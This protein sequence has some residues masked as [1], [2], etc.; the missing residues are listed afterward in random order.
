MSSYPNHVLVLLEW[1]DGALTPGGVS[2]DEPSTLKELVEEIDRSMNASHFGGQ[3]RLTLPST[4]LVS[5]LL[6]ARVA[7]DNERYTF[8]DRLRAAM[9]GT[10]FDYISRDCGR[11]DDGF[12]IK[13]AAFVPPDHAVDTRT[14]H[15]PEGVDTWSDAMVRLI[16][17]AFR[18]PK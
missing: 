12:Y 15:R 2:R 11:D 14:V 8:N 3:I 13:A 4:T 5:T 9:K 16:V 1:R 10:G 7:K 18:M 17:Q 6:S